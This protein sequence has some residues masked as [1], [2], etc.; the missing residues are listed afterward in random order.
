[1]SGFEYITEPVD[2]L[3]DVR[4]V[5][6]GGRGGVGQQFIVT[7]RRLLIGPVDT[8]IAQ[9]I[10]TYLL[11]TA[12]GPGDVLK[13]VLSHY[14]PM[15]PKIIWLRHIVD[16]QPTNRASA[17]KAPGI[18][19]ATDTEESINISIVA[20]PTTWTGS[21]KNNDARDRAIEVI[22]RAVAE[23]KAAVPPRTG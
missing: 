1:M 11:S 9:D 21:A 17:F 8:G 3:E 23:A 19:I 12:G 2:E 7:N 10:D 16:V 18:R 15:N 22:R 5:F 6:Y 20:T 4:G 14:A 13:G